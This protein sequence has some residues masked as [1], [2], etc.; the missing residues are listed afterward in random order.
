MI[1]ICY[2]CSE[3]LMFG[4]WRFA[5]ANSLWWIHVII[6]TFEKELFTYLLV[7]VW[8]CVSVSV[9][10]CVGVCMSVHLWV[11]GVILYH[12][13]LTPLRQGLSLNPKF[14]FSPLAWTLANLSPLLFLST[15]V[16][17]FQVSIKTVI[18]LCGSW[19]LNSHPQDCLDVLLTSEPSLQFPPPASLSL[20][21]FQSLESSLSGVSID[22]LVFW[23]RHSM[24]NFFVL[25]LLTT[26]YLYCYGVLLAN[27]TGLSWRYLIWR[28]LS[29]EW[30][31]H[32]FV[33]LFWG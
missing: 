26:L 7:W 30:N 28:A 25:L 29:F 5:V 32:A 19:D 18:S 33:S 8:A 1:D 9:C 31:I 20:T 22:I 14:T 2:T 10:R 12:C 27:S 11:F 13:L 21:T 17:W 4:T 6:S 3:L 24:L 16:L 23:S 15:S